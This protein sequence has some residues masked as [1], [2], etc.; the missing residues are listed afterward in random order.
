LNVLTDVT[1]DGLAAVTTVEQTLKSVAV[2]IAL[3]VADEGWVADAAWVW[4]VSIVE[5]AV[6][7]VA[8]FRPIA[9]LIE[10]V[11][12]GTLAIGEGAGV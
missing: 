3:V 1:S 4:A 5:V 9:V 7:V 11:I 8:Y 12:N 6:F 2:F 10:K